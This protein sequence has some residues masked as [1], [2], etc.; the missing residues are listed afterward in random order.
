MGKTVMYN[1]L[2]L[3][4]PPVIHSTRIYSVPSRRGPQHSLPS[5]SPGRD[6]EA[7]ETWESLKEGMTKICLTVFGNTSHNFRH[8]VRDED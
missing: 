4:K 1:S 6:K 7:E 5:E 8:A 3:Q 2:F